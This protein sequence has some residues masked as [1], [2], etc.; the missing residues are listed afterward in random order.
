MPRL[1]LEDQ[2]HAFI[3]VLEIEHC[4][5]VLR[6]SCA[7][8]SD[9]LESV[10]HLIP[11]NELW[12]TFD[13]SLVEFQKLSVRNMTVSDKT[14]RART[15][16]A[17]DLKGL[18][19][20]HAAGRSI[21][22]FLRVREGRKLTSLS[23]STS[24]VFDASDR[25]PSAAVV[26]WARQK[27]RQIGSSANRDKSFL[28]SFAATVDLS[29]VL[30]RSNPSALLIESGRLAELLMERSARL[31]TV[32]DGVKRWLSTDLQERVLEALERVFEIGSKAENGRDFEVVGAKAELRVNKASLSIRSKSLQRIHVDI[33]GDVSTLQSL[34]VK[35]NLFCVCFDDPKYMYFMGQCFE[36]S[37][38][39]SQ[40]E[41][42]LE[43]LHPHAELSRATSEKGEPFSR[44][45]TRFKPT[46]VFDVVERMHAA[47]DFVFCDD[48]GIEWADHIVLNRNEGVIT[49]IHSKHGKQSTS[50]SKLHD[51]VGQGIKNLGNM[52]FD[53]DQ[54]MS[55]YASKLRLDYDSTQ[56]NRKRRGREAE[57]RP[58]LKALLANYGTQRRCVLA[59]DFISKAD[60]S[61]QFARVKARQPVKG[62]IIQ[63]LWIL[64]SFSHAAKEVSVEPRIY[65]EP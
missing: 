18:V 64:S 46:S 37:S 55:K 33:G 40:I 7:N 28:S 59:C 10:G 45:Q 51:V 60:V 27:I 6:K 15:L 16:E 58:T 8:I 14:L 2:I 30:A 43:M 26:E 19:S 23:L 38:G 41:S 47:E 61:A 12:S 32:E 35:G 34:I 29:A 53:V 62:H 63:L 25:V 50:A 9:Q 4:I 36:D 5:V 1:Q 31:F 52:F 54:F 24:R 13:D 3:L 49:F 56:I 22:Y 44:S 11:P 57:L 65:C 20:T 48:K 42:L 21:P 17:A 39:V